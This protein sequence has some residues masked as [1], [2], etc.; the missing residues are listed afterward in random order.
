MCMSVRPSVQFFFSSSIL[1]RLSLIGLPGLDQLDRQNADINELPQ[2]NQNQEAMESHDGLCQCFIA[3][4]QIK[5]LAALQSAILP[6][7]KGT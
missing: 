3:A 5:D 7:N 6:G 1:I 4:V 2:P